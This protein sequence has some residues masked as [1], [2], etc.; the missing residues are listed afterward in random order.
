MKGAITSY[1]DVAQ[2]GIWMFW[3][4]FVGVIIYLRREAR[5][6]WDKIL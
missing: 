2:V 5:G 1:I 4:F 6:E 3:I